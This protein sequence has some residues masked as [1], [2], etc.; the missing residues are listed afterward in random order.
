MGKTV[1]IQAGARTKVFRLFS[2]SVP[3]TINFDATAKD[4]D[5]SG[6]VEVDRWH[7]FSWKR[8]TF[9]LQSRNSIEKGFAD[10]D[11]IIHVTPD[12]D[13]ELVF[14]GKGAG[15]GLVVIVLAALAIV[16]IAVA[17][18]LLSAPPPGG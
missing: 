6:I 12:Q 7:W 4:G 2:S 3:S 16:A 13:C 8:E 15:R 18:V 5:I 14:T 1:D 11:F 17:M 9:P 10:A